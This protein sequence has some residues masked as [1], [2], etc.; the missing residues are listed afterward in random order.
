MSNNSK[1]KIMETKIW[2]SAEKKEFRDGTSGWK[3]FVSGLEGKLNCEMN[4]RE[5]LKAMR[6]AFMLSKRLDVQI[7]SLHLAA[8]T[9]DYR[10]TKAQ[11][12]SHEGEDNNGE[13]DSSSEESAPEVKSEDTVADSPILKQWRELKT[14]HP[15]ALLLFRCGDFYETYCDDAKQAADTLGITLTRR[16]SD[17]VQMAGFPFHALDTYL[18]KLIRAGIRVAICD[19][20]EVPKATAKRGITELV[21]PKGA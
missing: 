10:R 2:I 12:E 14:K 7:D 21:S 4:F 8:L 17:K 6:Y 20:L 15:E 19:Q 9:V 1:F 16:S 3:V 5:P 13:Q 18:P 11:S